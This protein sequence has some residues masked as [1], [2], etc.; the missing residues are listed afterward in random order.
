MELSSVSNGGFLAVLRGSIL[1]LKSSCFALDG[2]LLSA[3][4]SRLEY[5]FRRH[6]AAA[7]PQDLALVFDILSSNG[8]KEDCVK[9]YT[10]VRRSA[11]RSTLADLNLDCFDVEI[12][13]A[14]E[15]KSYE[16]SI[17][18]WQKALDFTI[19]DVLEEEHKLSETVLPDSEAEICFSEIAAQA[20]IIRFL[21]FALQVTYCRND[22]YKLLKLLDIFST[23]DRL[24]LNF[25]KLF[26]GK[27]H[28]NI[29]ST[30]RDLIRKV[31]DGACGIFWELLFQV[32]LQKINPPPED[33]GVPKLVAAIVAFCNTLLGEDYISALVQVLQI[34]HSWRGEDFS[35]ELLPEA[36]VNV[37]GA[38]EENLKSWSDRYRDPAQARLFLVNSYW[39]FSK[40]LRG[41]DLGNLL[42]ENRLQRYRQYGD[43]H[44]E[45]YF[46]ESWGKLPRL[47]LRNKLREFESEF[48][49][50]HRKH[51]LWIV[52]EEDL[53]TEILQMI[54]KNLIPQ[55]RSFLKR[56][57]GD[58][59]DEARKKISSMEGMIF[60]LFHGRHLSLI[61]SN[62][63][64]SSK[65]MM[66][67]RIN[68]VRLQLPA[69]AGV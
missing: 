26:C 44:L 57:R 27:F 25:N 5:E 45:V 18:R 22:P 16:E 52:P 39:H 47:L 11:V 62:L 40:H 1:S 68:G 7:R 20:D 33:A 21:G 53:R 4:L 54:A 42:G 67:N 30:T 10:E 38:L 69:P 34:N 23:L 12:T 15:A 29:R 66:G 55:Y 50:I 41:T 35:P 46:N 63:S 51:S 14:E 19:K 59:D 58:H 37:A 2:G 43:Q 65:G 8:R 32:Q 13:D 56:Y 64:L 48:E 61:R 3:A 49:E 6:V 31:V 60:S 17:S 36:I 24:R 28:G 9:I